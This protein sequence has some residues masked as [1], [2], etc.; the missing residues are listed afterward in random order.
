MSWKY[1]LSRVSSSYLSWSGTC[2][3]LIALGGLS[4]AAHLNLEKE[5][6]YSDIC[7][8]VDGHCLLKCWWMALSAFVLDF[9]VADWNR[10]GCLGAP[11]LCVVSW[12][13]NFAQHMWSTKCSKIWVQFSSRNDFPRTGVNSE[14]RNWLLWN[15]GELLS[16]GL[17][18]C[19]EMYS[20]KCARRRT[21]T[22]ACQHWHP[23]FL[24]CLT[25]TA[26]TFN[27]ESF[28]FNWCRCTVCRKQCFAI[29][30]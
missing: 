28:C 14:K 16:F 10:Y 1:C 15:E 17:S 18:G 24:V 19:L 26:S 4:G 5:T 7:G 3:I 29:W 11:V 13:R 2:Y 25:K 22:W 8:L 9:C 21:R 23:A 20:W 12:N 6:V 27:E 30:E